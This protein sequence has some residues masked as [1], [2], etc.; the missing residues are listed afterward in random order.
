MEK[1]LIYSYDK[2]RDV[3]YVSVGK[4]QVA[5]GNP[6]ADDVFALVTPAKKRVVGFTIVNFKKHFVKAKNEKYPSFRIP[7]K[8]EFFLPV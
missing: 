4:P 1:D 2:E 6:I 7:V 3:M 8:A 5:I